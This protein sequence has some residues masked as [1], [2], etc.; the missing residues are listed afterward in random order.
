MHHLQFEFEFE[1][2]R[3]EQR[4]QNFWRREKV[5]NLYFFLTLTTSEKEMRKFVEKEKT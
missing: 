4:K 2:N 1:E 3:D 5:E